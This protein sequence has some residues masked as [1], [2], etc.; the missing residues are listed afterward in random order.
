MVAV[1]QMVQ[2][3]HL[4][5]SHQQVAAEVLYHIQQQVLVVQAAVAVLLVLLMETEHLAKEI[6][7]VAELLIVPMQ[8]AQEVAVVQAVVA[9]MLQ[10]LTVVAEAQVQLH[11]TLVHQ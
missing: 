3:L 6:T 9:A 8:V 10:V 7:A 4:L 2:I 11:H 5:Q 1:G